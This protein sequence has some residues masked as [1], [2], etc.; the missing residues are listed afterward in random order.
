[1]AEIEEALA[2][3]GIEEQL[4][5]DWPGDRARERARTRA[6]N[7]REPRGTQH[8]LEFLGQEEISSPI[9][10]SAARSRA[11]SSIGSEMS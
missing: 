9:P 5:Q 6:A 1:M 2:A 11:F 8:G 4:A 3:L 10:C 7:L